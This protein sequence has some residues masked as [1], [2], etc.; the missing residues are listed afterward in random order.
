[1]KRFW[2]KKEIFAILMVSPIFLYANAGTPLMWANAFHLLIGNA[3]I[4]IVEGLIASFLSLKTKK[5]SVFFFILLNYISMVLGLLIIFTI[6]AFGFE[7]TVVT[8]EN[9]K[10]FMYASFS[11]FYLATL[12]V[13]FPFILGFFWKENNRMKKALK[14]TLIVNTVSYAMIF[15]LYWFASS[16]TMVN[17][18]EVVSPEVI[19]LPEGYDLY[20]ISEDGAEVVKCSLNENKK[21]VIYKTSKIDSNEFLVTVENEKNKFDLYINFREE[22]A[23]KDVAVLAP[24]KKFHK[25]VFEKLVF[26]D[27]TPYSEWEYH[28][29]VYSI[30]GIYGRN[31]KNGESFRYSLDTPFLSWYPRNGT[32]V[33]KDLL[34]FQLGS[35]QIVALRHEKKQIALIARGFGPIV[36]KK[37]KEAIVT[38]KTLSWR[39]E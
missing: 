8:I 26:N 18:L 10:V 7:K 13:E 23:K 27:L 3:I 24:E 37:A 31:E 6:E 33:E 2:L 34:I 5:R 29:G 9:V 15:P 35:D 32:H 19:G 25:S 38:I 14:T 17:E 30:E 16:A 28:R 4:G 12:F 36:I 11:F 20:Y 22:L 1:M 39:N 21:E